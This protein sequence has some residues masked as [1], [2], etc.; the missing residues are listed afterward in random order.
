[1]NR[2][3]E[4]ELEAPPSCYAE[5]DASGIWAPVLMPLDETLNIDQQRFLQHANWCLDHGCHGIALF[6]TTSEANSFSVDE[7]MVLLDAAI[8][9]GIDPTRMMVGT[10]CCAITDSVR[11]T[12]HAVANGCTKTLVLPPF[13]YKGVSDQG[14][15]RSFAALID[16]VAD[17]SLRIYLYHFP[18]LSGAPITPGLIDLL[19]ARYPT[20]VVGIKDSSGDWANTSALLDAFPSLAVFPGT[21]LLLLD[22]LRAGGCGCITATANINPTGIRAVF[23]TWQSE[24]DGAGPVQEAAARI[25]KIVQARPTVPTLKFLNAHYRDDGNWARVRP[26]MLE[27][28]SDVGI[29]LVDELKAADFIYPGD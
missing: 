4:N 11:L 21:E 6:G 24:P 8:T 15:F 1:M 18:A 25:R 17:D 9:G 16:Q 14:L 28:P 3:T 5:H 20:T 2:T 13:Y 27:L 10:G 7:R 29:Q 22:G 12:R 23:D 19:L 26:P